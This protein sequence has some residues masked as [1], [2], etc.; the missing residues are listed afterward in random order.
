LIL[1]QSGGRL[2]VLVRRAVL[3]GLGLLP[4][5][6]VQLWINTFVAGSNATPGGLNTMTRSPWQRLL[7]GVS[8]LHTANI[9]WAFWLPGKVLSL[10]FPRRRP[11][12]CHGELALTAVA[13]VLLTIA[14]SCMRRTQ[15]HRPGIRGSSLG[16]FIAIPGMLLTAMTLGSYNYVGDQRYYVPAVPLSLF[17]AYSMAAMRPVRAR[18][19]FDAAARA[20][21]RLYCPD[22]W[23]WLLSMLF[24]PCPSESALPSAR[25]CWPGK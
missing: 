13:L 23:R 25:R 1:W 17:V 3:F 16:L 19:L 2:A 12:D 4:L 7:E 22:T 11:G 6:A 15:R 21:G 10:L 9:V 8:L 14:A 5:V 24:S 18:T 20:C